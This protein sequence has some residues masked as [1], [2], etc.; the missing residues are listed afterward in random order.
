MRVLAETESA[1][2]NLYVPHPATT[3]DPGNHSPEKILEPRCVLVPEG[4]FLMGCEE[5]RDE[6]RPVHRVWVETFEMAVFQVRKCDFDAFVRVT[7]HSAPPTWAD[8]DFNHPLQP[9]VSV[10]WF[11]AAKYCEWL[12]AA[13]GRNYRLPTE[14]EWERAARGGRK[15]FLYPWGNEEPQ[16]RAEYLRRWGGEAKGPLPV[17]EGEPNPFGIFDLCENVHEWCADW[18]DRDYYG[19]SPARNP[20][21]PAGGERRASRGGSW[22]HHVKVSRCAARSSIPPIFQYAD[23]GFRVVRDV[24]RS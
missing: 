22:R 5:G 13:T 1:R 19:V 21:G 15:G 2:R 10:N 17:G 4:E 7:G 24:R 6:E 3:K 23:Y 9:V 16:A 11:E 14:A 12:S 20:R 18:F 8:A